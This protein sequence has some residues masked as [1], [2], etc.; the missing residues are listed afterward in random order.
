MREL[1]AD[2]ASAPGSKAFLPDMYAR[3]LD[4]VFIRF[5]LVDIEQSSFHVFI[6]PSTG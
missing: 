1:I 3:N 5:S 2:S 6:H 4:R